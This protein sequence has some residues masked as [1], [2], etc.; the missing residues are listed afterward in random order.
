MKLKG[1]SRDE[2]LD[3]VAGQL[4]AFFPDRHA[5]DARR[6]ID[7]DLDETLDRLSV[8]VN[9]V[10]WWPQ[11]AFDYLHSA[12]HCIF[13]YYLANTIWRNREHEN[14]CTKL[15][16]LNKA[17][18]GFECFY[19]TALPDKF[20]IGH[21]VGI[22]LAR[23]TYSNYL[24]LYQGC[25]VGKNHGAGPILEDAVVLYP[26]SAVIGDCRVRTRTVI[27]QGSSIVDTDTPGNSYVF[28]NNGTPV[29][30]EMKRDVFADIFRL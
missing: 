21:S 30:K 8:C 6:V 25:T 10:R 11:D 7:Q 22:V 2:L 27:G 24:V 13:V 4:T 9:A 15:F 12:Q 20:F 17:V 26:N 5:G 14:V 18:N 19:N 29:F 28:S 1:I 3:Y 16:C 23:A